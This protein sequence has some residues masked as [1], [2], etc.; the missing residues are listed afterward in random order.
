MAML[1]NRGGNSLSL[2]YG[3]HI[4]KMTLD[5]ALD[6]VI[7]G[8]M[9]PMKLYGQLPSELE[10]FVLEIARKQFGDEFVSLQ[11]D[12]QKIALAALKDALHRKNESLTL[13]Q[14]ME[15]VIKGTMDAD[16]VVGQMPQEAQRVLNEAAKAIFSKEGFA[17]LDTEQKK[18]LFQLVL[19]SS[20]REAKP[21]R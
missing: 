3:P 13:A 9:D 8:A 21:T 4:V 6:R 12:Q 11:S 2:D 5:E 14:A 7:T 20:A 19:D 16:H 18:R 10:E 1:S 17:G 15:R